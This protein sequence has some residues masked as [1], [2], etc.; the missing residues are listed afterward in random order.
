MDDQ[1]I[2]EAIAKIKS[3]SKKRNFTQSYDLILNL[4]DIDIKKQDG[5]IDI[6][7]NLP[8]PTGKVIKVCGLVGP[9]MIDDAKATFH[10]AI[11]QDDFANLAKNKKEM[12]KIA[13]ECDY[14]VAQA[15][16]MGKVAGAFGRVLGPKGKMPNPK[17][18]CV[19]PPKTNLNILQ[20]KL[21]KM[22]HVSTKK[23]AIIKIGVGKEDLD[24][25]SI[26]QNIMHAY[27]TIVHH[28]PLEKNNLKSVLLKL[29]MSK[30]VKLE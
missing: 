26:T 20:E 7:V 13:E 6:Y 16:I 9:E 10:S 15:N 18:G 19:V 25:K 24:D 2:K 30:T 23:E 14:F 17:A 8:H 4:K 1:T 12:K 28:L 29:T 3:D 11:V 21:G 22:V 27:N 5:Q